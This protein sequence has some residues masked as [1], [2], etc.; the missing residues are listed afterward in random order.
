MQNECVS[1]PTIVIFSAG[2]LMTQGKI[3]RSTELSN[4][5]GCMQSQATSGEVWTPEI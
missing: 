5:T 1:Y 2:L 3:A 4:S